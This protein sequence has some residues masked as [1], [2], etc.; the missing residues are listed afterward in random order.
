ML[1]DERIVGVES[2]SQ[3][4]DR[5]TLRRPPPSPP[6]SVG[7][8][9]VRVIEPEPWELGQGHR[10]GGRVNLALQNEQGN[11]A[12]RELD[13]DLELD[14][15]RLRDQF[16]SFGQLEYDT[17]RGVRT[18]DKWRLNNKYSRFFK[19]SPWYA[20]GW[21][22]L[23]HDDFADVRL[24]SLVGPA[25]GYKFVEGPALNL[26]AEVGP[27]YLYEDFYQQDDTVAWGPGLLLDDDQSLWNDHLQRYHRSM[28][29]TS[30][31]V[32]DP[33]LW[34][35]WTGLRMPMAWGVVGS[36][37]VEIDYDSEPAPGTKTTDTTLK[38]KIGY[39]W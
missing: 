29:Y 22:R 26:R 33:D 3:D 14:Y 28:G 17:T 10:L 8:S 12:K 2:V 30:V 4:G 39:E 36:L 13:L 35:S 24:R 11:S 15:R 16:E 20:S 1:D 32:G 38:L 5:L 31:G 19:G 34:V 37:E 6:M 18:T 25:V 9:H 7:A 21:L 27:I 23:Y